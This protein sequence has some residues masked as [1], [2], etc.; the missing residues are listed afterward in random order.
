MFGRLLLWIERPLQSCGLNETDMLGFSPFFGV[1]FYG[2]ETVLIRYRGKVKLA[3][4][5]WLRFDIYN[6]DE[7]FSLVVGFAKN[8]YNFRSVWY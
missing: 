4:S 2:I 1:C 5:V 3:T 7:M 8:Q 6:R